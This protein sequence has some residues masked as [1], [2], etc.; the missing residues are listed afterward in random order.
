M[1]GNDVMNAPLPTMS[2]REMRDWH[3][4]DENAGFGALSTE[5][6]NLPLSA[7]N[8]SARIV[9]LLADVSLTQTFVNTHDE[10]IEAT[11]IFPLPDRAAVTSF[12]MEVAG[13]VIDGVLEER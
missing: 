5:R 12:R 4:R 8:V 3:A 6:G 2:E 13:R 10:P 7:M 9:G 11:Y 1:K